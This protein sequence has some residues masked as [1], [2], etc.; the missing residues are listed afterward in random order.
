M[1]EAILIEVTVACGLGLFV[2]GAPLPTAA[3]RL[4]GAVS[5]REGRAWHQGTLVGESRAPCSQARLYAPAP[6]GHSTL[7]S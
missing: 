6:T 3:H 2:P 4:G 5:G 1:V 7:L